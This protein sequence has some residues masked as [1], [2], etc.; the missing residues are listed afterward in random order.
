MKERIIPMKPRTDPLGKGLSALLPIS[1][2]ATGTST[3]RL[4]RTF[5]YCPVESIKPNPDQPRK[6][7]DTKALENLAAS[8]IDKGVIQPLVVRE[9]IGEDKT[10]YELIAGERRWRAAQL[11]GLKKVP[12][13]IKNATKMERLEL[14][15]IE[16]IQRQDLNPID[17]AESYQRL[18]SEFNLT[19]ED[20]SKKVGK[21]RSTVANT[22]RLLQLP[23]Y[24]REDIVA[25]KLSPGHARALLSLEDA[26]SIR[27]LRDEI[28]AKKLS[29][30]EA[31][32]QA[33]TIKAQ[34]TIPDGTAPPKIKSAA[35]P[36]IP[37]SYCRTLS[38]N[39]SNYLGTK[40]K[41][42]QNGA[43]GKLEIEYYSADD[44]ERVM[45]L[46]IK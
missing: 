21:E 44:L 37:D 7:M 14:A 29:V 19:Q 25:K 41:I 17:E 16:N 3:D 46:I 38:S 10:Y 27:T 4:H 20:I 13:V 15:L 24:A 11:A 43:R 2:D 36:V 26:N 39:L 18:L 30:R 5:F 23:D 45:G 31:E 32:A 6:E 40:S 33:K 35:E 12:V 1:D 28:V 34:S 9:I 22:L 8:I 42:V